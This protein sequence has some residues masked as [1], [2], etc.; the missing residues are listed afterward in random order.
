MIIFFRLNLLLNFR[1]SVYLLSPCIQVGRSDAPV[2]NGSD[3][4]VVVSGEPDNEQV[5]T[6]DC[7]LTVHEPV[8]FFKSGVRPG[9]IP[10]LRKP[11]DLQCV[12]F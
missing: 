1:G 9:Q 10:R 8:M 2:D 11:E 7:Y 4:E 6:L 5:V 3:E 12:S